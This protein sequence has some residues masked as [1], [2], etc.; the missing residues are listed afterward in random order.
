VLMPKPK[1]AVGSGDARLMPGNRSCRE[2]VMDRN[3]P[4]QMRRR[5]TSVRKKFVRGPL[6]SLE[7]IFFRNET[8]CPTPIIAQGCASPLH[9]V[10]DSARTAGLDSIGGAVGGT[11]DA[12][13]PCALAVP[14]IVTTPL[15]GASCRKPALYAG[16]AFSFSA[17]P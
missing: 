9:R 10:S 11:V 13:N 12:I 4:C 2:R 8:Q 3:H 5:S 7:R 1:Y 14:I 17:A 16:L 15:P 6:R